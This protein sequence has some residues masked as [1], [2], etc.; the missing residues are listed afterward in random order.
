[1]DAAHPGHPEATSRT[2]RTILVGL[3][4]IGAIAWL[5]V[6]AAALHDYPHAED[7]PDP[8]GAGL[9]AMLDVAG[10]I[11]GLFGAA[12]AAGA[13]AAGTLG[14]RVLSVVLLSI[15]AGSPVVAVAGFVAWILL[16]PS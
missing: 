5:A 3:G 10:I 8:V 16:L 11:V 13:A 4:L 15:S 7:Y 9:E 2:A 6:A 1:M 12:C 14:R